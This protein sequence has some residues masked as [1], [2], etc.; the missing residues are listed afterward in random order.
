[1]LGGFSSAESEETDS[2]IKPSDPNPHQ[3]IFVAAYFKAEH[4]RF[5]PGKELDDG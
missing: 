3:W 4:R 5:K 2:Q 1:M